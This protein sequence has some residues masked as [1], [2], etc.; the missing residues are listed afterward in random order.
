VENEK[1]SVRI[2]AGVST[3]SKIRVPGKGRSEEGDLY[4]SLIVEAHPY[5]SRNGDDIL[6]EVPVTVAEAYLGAEIEVPT[7]RGSVR[8]KIPPGTASGQKFRLKGYGIE[9]TRTGSTGDHY[10][11]ISIV[12]PKR[13]TS[14]G[15]EA[16]ET[17]SRL[18]DANP[19]LSL[20]KGL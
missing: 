12:M 7:I 3:G 8:A 5:F 6:A 20:P 17:F 14:E 18:Y 16:A 2:P 11:R 9:N 4:L 13:Q 1:V 10:Y 15:R 19:R